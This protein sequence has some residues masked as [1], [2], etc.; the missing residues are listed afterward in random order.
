MLTFLWL[1]SLAVVVLLSIWPF[2]FD[3][4][5]VDGE[6]WTALANSWG[7]HTSRGDI[8]GN[9]VLFIPVGVLGMFAL[10]KVPFLNRMLLVV[11]ISFVVA[12]GVQVLQVA[13]PDRSATMVDVTWNMV[14]LLPGLALVVIPW[15]PIVAKLR[16]PT[17][18]YLLPLMI[19][20][21][22]VAYRLAPY[23]PSVDFQL[24]KD[25]LKPLLVT[26][27]FNPVDIF[28]NMAA[29]LAVA[30]LLK[31]ADREQ[32]LDRYVPLLMAG[33]FSAEVIIAQGGG[34]SMPNI[35]GAA[36]ALVVWF[37]GLRR[38]PKAA[39]ALSIIMVAALVL[40]GL[41]P[42]AFAGPAR[43]FGWM[44]FSG[45]LG[46][47]M[48]LNV[49]AI[50]EKTFFF[51]A[52][53]F[54]LWQAVGKWTWAAGIIAPVVLLVEVLQTFQPGRSAEIT[55]PLLVVLACAAGYALRGFRWRDG[56][57]IDESDE[58]APAGTTS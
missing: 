26:P 38:F 56:H 22:W 46:G 41:S 35:L 4:S 49:F 48:A 36:L 47:S 9:V 24:I 13:I 28:S 57:I 58:K 33:V 25:N 32:R 27:S 20:G 16:L 34:V 15:Q 31:A 43:S 14:G 55:D 45:L 8:L 6:A 2:N 37:G 21:V 12:A 18:V 42:F 1:A 19:V 10:R 30:F 11:G 51:A 52:A 50:V 7:W 3:F 39:H 53:S 40:D 44:P 17:D 29:W 23:L 54:A 5:V